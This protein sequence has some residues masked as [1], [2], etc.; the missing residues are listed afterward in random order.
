MKKP[1]N[2]LIV[3]AGDEYRRKNSQFSETTG[4]AKSNRTRYRVNDSNSYGSFFLLCYSVQLCKVQKDRQL[5]YKE[6]AIRISEFS[7][8]F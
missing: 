3:I 4:Y 1:Q 6:L 2:I 5:S 7:N 8:I